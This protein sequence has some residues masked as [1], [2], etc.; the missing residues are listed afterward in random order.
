MGY[1]SG[2]CGW[3]AIDTR[4]G[5]RNSRKHRVVAIPRTGWR[6]AAVYTLNRQRAVDISISRHLLENPWTLLPHRCSSSSTPL[7]TTPHRDRIILCY[8]LARTFA[9]PASTAP[10]PRRASPRW[11]GRTGAAPPPVSPPETA[12]ALG[13]PAPKR[14]PFPQNPTPP[15]VAAAA[16]AAAASAAAVAYAYI[17]AR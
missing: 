2:G 16:A 12:A 9:A 8:T 15:T 4:S 10:E 13:A 5:W 7:A 3:V 17:H 1:V 14:H 11:P 6:R